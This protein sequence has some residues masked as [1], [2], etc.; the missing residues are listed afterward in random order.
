[1]L[2]AIRKSNYL[3]SLLSIEKENSAKEIHTQTSPVKK[4][5]LVPPKPLPIM[6][7]IQPP[8]P[9]SSPQN[10]L[11]G[12]GY[13]FLQDSRIDISP[14]MDPA[15]VAVSSVAPL[16]PQRIPNYDSASAY[17]LD[18]KFEE[19]STRNNLRV[20][21]RANTNH[22][23]K[24]KK[25]AEKIEEWNPE[26]SQEWASA[27]PSED[28]NANSKK[29]MK[30]EGAEWPYANAHEQ[31]PE[32]AK[33]GWAFPAKESVTKPEMEEW[34]PKESPVPIPTVTKSGN[35]MEEWNTAC[36]PKE[37]IE[38]EEWNTACPPKEKIGDTANGMDEWNRP[39]ETTPQVVNGIN[40][41]TTV[42]PSPTANDDNA[43]FQGENPTAKE[44]AHVDREDWVISPA[45][46]TSDEWGT[47]FNSKGKP[48]ELS[49]EEIW[50]Q[51]T[52]SATNGGTN[53][54]MGGSYQKRRNKAASRSRGRGSHNGYG[55]DQGRDHNRDYNRDQNRDYNRDFNSRGEFPNRGDG[56]H[57]N[58]VRDPN[59][60]NRSRDS[61]YSNGRGGGNFHGQ[62]QRYDQDQI[63]VGEY[64]RGGGN[65]RGNFR[66]ASS[67]TGEHA[68]TRG[69]GDF[70][71]PR[72]NY[73]RNAPPTM[74]Y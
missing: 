62:E 48:E 14:H 21:K 17:S 18:N 47:T 53:M 44:E 71:P 67:L 34:A 31:Q 69:G 37:K 65:F 2:I 63:E 9:P 70:R 57:S 59:L 46:P 35:E 16:M 22:T 74:L 58:Y 15:V 54:S 49:N 64:K 61:G 11:L 20:S 45:P 50:S 56:P 29:W 12:S 66:G 27:K 3:S 51:M 8:K 13:N 5:I 25:K 4:E 60:Q 42:T 41:W 39:K 38:M 28:G 33:E 32:V 23:A 30:P 10:L 7:G 36:P 68:Y 6:H 1:M 52:Q 24:S 26:I 40:E 43:A 19:Q 72:G 73:R 55:R